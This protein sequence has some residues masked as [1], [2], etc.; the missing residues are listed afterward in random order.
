ML[1]VANNETTSFDFYTLG[2][3]TS[4][5]N[6]INDY[7]N[8]FIHSDAYGRLANSRIH[9][10][11]GTGYIYDDDGEV[12][13]PANGAQ[14]GFV[15]ASGLVAPDSSLNR[16]FVLGQTTDQAASNSY[17]IQSFDQ[18]TLALVGSVTISGIVGSPMKLIR[19][20][21]T[22]LALAAYG[23]SNYVSNQPYGM[24]YILNNPTFVSASQSRTQLGVE[25]ELVQRRWI[26]ATSPKNVPRGLRH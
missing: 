14:V 21:N 13:N 15:G 3:S 2:V 23:S 16:I 25:P 11:P 5:V 10:D 9:F 17:T 18:K 6:L 22:G 4:G 12:I 20:G 26:P 7:P 1:Y 8:T 24:L 19:W